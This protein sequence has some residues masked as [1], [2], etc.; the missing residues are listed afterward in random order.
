[1]KKPI[2]LTTSVTLVLA[3]LMMISC[4]NGTTA[5]SSSTATSTSNLNKWKP[6]YA[7]ENS[8]E[9]GGDNL[10]IDGD[11]DSAD[12]KIKL[13]SGDVEVN[14]WVEAGTSISLSS[15]S[16]KNGVAGSN[17]AQFKKDT[18]NKENTYLMQVINVEPDMEYTLSANVKNLQDTKPLLAV[19][20]IDWKVLGKTTIQ[21]PKDWTEMS[22]VFNSGGSSQVRI[23]WYGATYGN[24]YENFKGTAYLD[25]VSV[26]KKDKKEVISLENNYRIT[27][28]ALS[29]TPW[30]GQYPAGWDWEIRELWWYGQVK[31]F[32]YNAEVVTN[33]KEPFQF[34]PGGKIKDSSKQGIYGLEFEW[35]TSMKEKTAYRW[36]FW[37]GNKSDIPDIIT[38]N[39]DIVWTKDL[40]FSS[41]ND[42]IEFEYAPESEGKATIR[43]IN[44]AHHNQGKNSFRYLWAPFTNQ[45]GK[46]NITCLS[47]PYYIKIPLYSKYYLPA[48]ASYS[49]TESEKQ[50]RDYFDTYMV[51]P[52]SEPVNIPAIDYLSSGV[53]ILEHWLPLPE[54]GTYYK[55]LGIT[56]SI[57]CPENITRRD[58][59]FE[60]WA[61]AAKQAGIKNI[62]L[63]PLMTLHDEWD[64]EDE[65]PGQYGYVQ[66]HMTMRG[67]MPGKYPLWEPDTRIVKIQKSIDA[68]TEVANRWLSLVPDGKVFMFGSEA[69]G[70]YGVY[71]GGIA[72]SDIGI[73]EG[74]GQII[75]GGRTA[76]ETAFRFM[77]DLKARLDLKLG[78]NKSKVIYLDQSD[79]AAFNVAYLF[80]SGA[81]MVMSKN[82]V[83][84]NANIA[85][86][87]SRG[88]S[89]AYNKDWA[90][91]FDSW[92]WGMWYSHTPE[93]IRHGMLSYFFAG[94]SAI[95]NEIPVWNFQESHLNKWG[96]S[97]LDFVRFTKVHPPLGSQQAGIGIIRG[98][99]DEWNSIRGTKQD[100][101]LKDYVYNDEMNK[102]LQ[103]NPVP[104]KWIG[105][106]KARNQK[107]GVEGED[108]Y[109]GDYDLLSL[110]FKDY[111]NSVRTDSTREFT[112]TPYGPADFLP[113]DVSPA[114]TSEYKAI[115][116]MGR[117]AGTDR[118][119]L[120]TL[121]GYAEKGGKLVIAAGQLKGDDGKFYSDD[122][123]GIDLGERKT[124]NELPY[125][126][127]SG[128]ESIAKLS[129]GDPAVVKIKYG[130]GE[131]YLFAGEYLTSMGQNVPVDV[132]KTVL[133]SASYISFSK[134]AD[135]IEYM[136]Q[137]K[138]ESRAISLL[139]H[140]RGWFPSGISKDQGIWSGKISIDL[141][142]LGLTG[143][144]EVYNVI[145]KIDGTTSVSL[146]KLDFVRKVNV[147]EIE[148]NID[149]L[150]EIIIGPVG[151]AKADFYS[152]KK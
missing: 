54:A 107:G 80:K 116:Y 16:K 98:I 85:T 60:D 47:S 44:E 5:P 128:G 88:I 49:K 129:G 79:S 134:Q 32:S 96:D 109:L 122:F 50:M 72:T 40:D 45:A 124:D 9:K 8:S 74:Y 150:Q 25:D 145:Q 93:A 23:M 66:W 17:C 27:S 126:K 11:F 132:L 94:P 65:T 121:L 6:L 110:I 152:N 95:M 100:W 137:N 33:D 73:F 136:I 1:M 41:D 63:F 38:V 20:S 114:A 48:D 13:Y 55:Q 130:K 141:N 46:A 78:K 24:I 118:S 57:Y 117:G 83:T 127:L 151:K 89:K 69:S 76:W 35:K 14:K 71:T 91:D 37:A 120:K 4:N 21:T 87:I 7:I 86:S 15:I 140:G 59:Y 123:A 90:I 131:I 84:Q 144:L 52:E 51:S 119:T 77:S 61:Q 2:F 58:N 139:N 138:G 108:T 67:G 92:D 104:D 30:E 56:T 82:I 148:A 42:S 135:Y 64:R 112:G 22:L 12:T 115:I 102:A 10:I 142:R 111:G 133:P 3:V 34:W 106:S 113:W 105:A 75:E 101:A 28:S 39:N 29:F 53:E 68:T 125:I 149:E 143:E 31:T 70:A 146:E 97:W 26:K 19:C 81:D 99:G 18:D 147:I 36:S 43:F 62:V 103:Q